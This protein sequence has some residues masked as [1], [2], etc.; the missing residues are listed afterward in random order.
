MTQRPAMRDGNL[1]RLNW[2][3]SPK[4]SPS[5]SAG[6]IVRP[7]G[8]PEARTTTLDDAGDV[9]ECSSPRD[10]DRVAPPTPAPGQEDEE[11]QPPEPV[12]W[13][14]ASRVNMAIT[15]AITVVRSRRSRSAWT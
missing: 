9:G 3:T 10:R 4:R 12:R 14:S 11:R 8:Y 1:Q 15:V 2:R 7:K 6:P 5:S 13:P